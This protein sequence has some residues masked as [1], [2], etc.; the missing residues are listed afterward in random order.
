MDP[1]HGS[2]LSSTSWGNDRPPPNIVTLQVAD[3]VLYC[4][5]SPAAPFGCPTE[6]GPYLIVIGGDFIAALH[7]LRKAAD[8]GHGPFRLR[9]IRRHD[10]LPVKVRV[11]I[12][13]GVSVGI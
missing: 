12:D 11:F 7:V 2:S 13:L 9:S 1:V 3:K 5:S 4:S 6:S 10:I 8:I